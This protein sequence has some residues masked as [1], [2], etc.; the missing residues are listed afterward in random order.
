MSDRIY[1]LTETTTAASGDKLIMDK[2]GNSQAEYIDFLHFK[3]SLLDGLDIGSNTGN[4]IV[5]NEAQQILSDKTL[6]SPRLNNPTLNSTDTISV[7]G[8]EVNTLDGI[9][10]NESIQDQLDDKLDAIV[11]QVYFRRMIVPDVS[12]TYHLSSSTIMSLLGLTGV[13][14][15]PYVN[16]TTFMTDGTGEYQD[17]SVNTRIY[18]KDVSGYEV[19]DYIA[20]ASCVAGREMYCTGWFN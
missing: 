19:I 12:G 6:T 15:S 4:S 16:L 7:T 18:T 10:T 5:T 8:D 11:G 17:W 1:E 3:S 20:F 9:D 13:E 2:S 14:L